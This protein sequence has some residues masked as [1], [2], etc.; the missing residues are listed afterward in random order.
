MAVFKNERKAVC[1]VCGASVSRFSRYCDNCGIA[2]KDI[3]EEPPAEERPT[4]D[5]TT[6]GRSPSSVRRIVIV[7][8]IAAVVAVIF[9]ATGVFIASIKTATEPHTEPV[10]QVP[11]IPPVQIT[12]ENGETS[13]TSEPSGTEG[14][15]YAYEE[16]LSYLSEGD[17]RN[18][19]YSLVLAGDYQDAGELAVRYF[20]EYV[21][22]V[23]GEI[24]SGIDGIAVRT[25]T[26]HGGLTVYFTFSSDY[27]EYFTADDESWA[28]L[29]DDMQ[30]IGEML[31]SMAGYS[32]YAG[33][34]D[35]KVTLV[36]ESE[37]GT[38]YLRVENGVIVNEP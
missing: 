21:N 10:S 28:D 20:P 31:Y 16:A 37:T 8:V 38:E 15:A 27:E 3:V 23:T 14:Q 4:A 33:N 22:M 34:G 32:G 6:A 11:E 30:Q 35:V 19:M 18:A 25:E 2:L 17:Y 5:M 9:I 13:E 7:A 29:R 12:V 36:L 24:F 26:E 1:P